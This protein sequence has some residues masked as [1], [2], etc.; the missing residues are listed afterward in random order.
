MKIL[1]LC[2]LLVTIGLSYSANEVKEEDNFNGVLQYD[3]QA[4][5]IYM[6]TLLE[7]KG[8]PKLSET[9]GMVEV[10]GWKLAE[11]AVGF[12]QENCEA[13]I[14][15]MDSF[16]FHAAFY[17]MEDENSEY[18]GYSASCLKVDEEL[19]DCLEI[20]GFYKIVGLNVGARVRKGIKVKDYFE[21]NKN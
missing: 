2:F 11:I 19:L 5:T 16:W 20:A 13:P 12:Y 17:N 18:N 21:K 15:K 4:L 14:G 6:P 7:V 3:G 10:K 1:C 9:E 8:I